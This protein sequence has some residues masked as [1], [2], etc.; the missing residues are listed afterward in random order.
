MHRLERLL[1]LATGL[2]I[3]VYL[4]FHFLNYALGI[5]S[6]D[7][8]EAMRG[9]VAP[10]WRSAP[11]S[12]LLYGA[13]LAH[14]ALALRS[15]YRRNTLRMP[16]W[17]ACQ[18]GLGLAIPPLL[19]AHVV[20]TR[21][22]WGLADREVD[23]ARVVSALW[24]DPWNAARQSLLLVLAWL[25]LCVGL[26]FW[27]RLKAWYPRALPALLSFAV[28]LPALALAGFVSAGSDLAP[29]I[30]RAAGP[31]RFFPDLAAV[32]DA[33]RALLA[34]WREALLWTFW[35]LLG[36][37]LAARSLRRWRWR[38]PAGTTPSSTAT[39]CSRCT[40]CAARSVPRAARRS[41]GRSRCSGASSG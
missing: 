36:A 4:L 34:G 31:Q 19:I 11:G 2:V 38:R 22:A 41:P 24:S 12:A 35:L 9:V 13:L 32:T 10:W 16:A 14:F 33:Q 39:V 5:V 7:A 37:T 26:H 30:A 29:L 8:M 1:R 3:A 20:G 18:L 27:L 6:V 40:A 25:H 21:F 15:L 17:E 23:Y 28:L